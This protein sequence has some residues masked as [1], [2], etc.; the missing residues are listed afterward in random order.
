MKTRS[1]H[2][3]TRLARRSLPLGLGLCAV[4]GVATAG[5]PADRTTVCVAPPR[6]QLEGGPQQIDSLRQRL[7]EQLRGQNREVLPLDA[8]PEQLDAEA[9]GKH[10][11]Y[12]LDTQVEQKHGSGAGGLFKKLVPLANVL[13]LGALTGRGGGAGMAGAASQLMAQGAANSFGQQQAA[14]P[15]AAAAPSGLKRGDTLSFEY[16]L[17]AVGSG[18]PIKADT[19]NAKADSDGEDVFGPMVGKLANAVTAATGGSDEAAKGTA[20][21]AAPPAPPANRGGM[22]GGLFGHKTPSPQQS[23]SGGPAPDCAQIASM[24]N[25]PM[26]LDACQKMLASQQQYSAAAADPSASRPGDDELSCEQI[27]AELRQQQISA[28]DKNKVAAAKDALAAEQ[29]VNSKQSAE[30]AKDAVRQQAEVDAASAVDRTAEMASFGMVQTHAGDAVG[31]KIIAENEARSER[32]AKERH[33]TDQKLGSTTADLTSDVAGQL[34]AN[35]RL[36]RLVQLADTHH[37]KGH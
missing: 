23:A 1:L 4:A 6:A 29:A 36:A 27:L 16:R 25:A 20:T 14:A 10:C 28:P 12:V 33:P 8:A 18:S 15:G 30:A 11:T 22:F 3:N 31:K 5:G 13:P 24:P 7:V 2:P 34:A 32:F 35:P 26:T 17:T 19:L 9:R 21:G 37:C